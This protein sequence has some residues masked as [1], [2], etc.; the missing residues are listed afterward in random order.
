[1]KSSAPDTSAER[2][3][4]QPGHSAASMPD[5]SARGWLCDAMLGKLA[6]ELR[7]LGMDVDYQRNMPSMQAYR[8]ARAAGRI[9]LT[10]NKRLAKLPGVIY[11]ESQ[12]PAAQV[13]QVRAA[14]ES[15]REKE[16]SAGKTPASPQTEPAATPFGR[17]L[18]CNSPLAQIS[19][20]QARPLVPFFVYQIHHD[21]R[22]CPKC[23]RVYWPGNHVQSMT[24]RVPVKTSTRQRRG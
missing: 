10:R 17:C 7:L 5:Q 13:A 9:M 16:P 11:I 14:A 24:Q 21:F 15:K 18:E 2:D 19:R 3:R 23:K 1:M 20:E 6:R 4:S 22:R 8:A 12:E